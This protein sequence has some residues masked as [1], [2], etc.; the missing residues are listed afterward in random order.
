MEKIL[1][2]EN[3]SSL[4]GLAAIVF[5]SHGIIV[6]NLTGEQFYPVNGPDRYQ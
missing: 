3:P 4:V 2:E 1:R 6:Q 5:D